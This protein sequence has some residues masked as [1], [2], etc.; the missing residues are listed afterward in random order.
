MN[1]YLNQDNTLSKRKWYDL[2][3]YDKE[4][5]SININEEI[6]NIINNL[7]I[8][9]NVNY[10]HLYV[11]S[12]IGNKTLDNNIIINLISN[13]EEFTEHDFNYEI[14]TSSNSDKISNE[15]EIFLSVKVCFLNY[16]NNLII[17]LNTQD[18]ININY[19]AYKKMYS[20]NT[21]NFKIICYN[22]MTFIFNISN[23]LLFSFT[24]VLN[25][26]QIINMLKVINHSIVNSKYINLNESNKIENNEFSNYWLKKLLW[27]IKYDNKNVKHNKFNLDVLTKEYI[28]SI[29]K[30]QITTNKNY[31]YL[32]L[33]E[34]F[35]I[36]NIL[37]LLFKYYNN[38]INIYLISNVLDDNNY[39][40]LEDKN[41]IS[42]CNIDINKKTINIS[43]E[44]K[45][46]FI[47]IKAAIFEF[48]DNINNY[49]INNFNNIILNECTN[50][51]S[52]K[53]IIQSIHNLNHLC[54]EY[55]NYIKYLKSKDTNND[56]LNLYE[57]FSNFKSIININIHS[58]NDDFNEIC[59]IWYNLIK[60]EV[61]KNCFKFYDDYLLT[62]SEF[63]ID[64]ANDKNNLN[65]LFNSK[66]KTII[67]YLFYKYNNYY[68][69]NYKNINQI[70][71]NKNKNKYN[72]N[73][74]NCFK[75]GESALKVL[76][77]KKQQDLLFNNNKSNTILNTK[78]LN[79][80]FDKKS[81]EVKD[82]TKSEKNEYSDYIKKYNLK[83]N[84]IELIINI[85]ED[86]NNNSIGDNKLK[87]LYNYLFS[88]NTELHQETNEYNEGNIYKI[89]GNLLYK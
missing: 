48:L 32:Y 42:S 8:K 71:I 49:K 21:L 55:N 53:S 62:I 74:N 15:E 88:T 54:L 38:N 57:K 86:Y 12:L 75:D 80:L 16:N 43:T 30:D 52:A 82:M 73:L 13:L 17:L 64:D 31:T 45:V 18:L 60:N 10:K 66:Y 23:I 24:D 47:K 65:I 34:T 68:T 77:D 9:E 40:V 46:E 83:I 3:N 59:M 51:N 56:Y 33:N 84:Y 6:L 39:N 26:N 37:D 63:N 70:K 35:T 4:S 85:I 2:I 20:I 72:F 7:T 29:V 19:E 22:I 61:N 50:I 44:L 11:F 36:E 67:K 78:I 89:L 79:N 28:I 41:K 14:Y 1:N 5:C 69:S 87:T 58:H 81:I 25:I 27:I 76:L